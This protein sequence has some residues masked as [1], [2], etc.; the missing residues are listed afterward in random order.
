M[1]EKTKTA[2]GKGGAEISWCRVWLILLAAIFVITCVATLTIP[3]ARPRG[4]ADWGR[5]LVFIPGLSALAAT[6]LWL[7]LWLCFHWR[8]AVF[9]LACAATVIALFYAEEDWRG[10]HA[11]NKFRR[12]WEAKGERFDFAS[13][14]PP[15]VPEDQNFALTPLV[16]SSYGQMLDRTGHRLQPRNTNLVARL[17]M[18][19]WDGGNPPGNLNG[20]A[21]GEA[22]DLTAFQ[23]YY[24]E[25]AAKTNLFPVPPTPQSP[26]ADVL[27]ALSRLDPTLEELRQDAELPYSRF[28]LDYDTENKAAIVLPHLAALKRC[29]QVLALRAT[30]ELQTGQS[31]RAL[32]DITLIQRLTE[33]IHSEPFLISHLVRIAMVQLALQPVWEGLAD[34]RWTGAQLTALDADLAKLDFL[35]GYKRGM[36]CEL[37]FQGAHLDYLQMHPGKYLEL[38]NEGGGEGSKMSAAEG[39]L[40]ILM[41]LHLAP[42]GWLY[43]NRLN[44]ALAMEKYYLPVA[45][46]QSRTFNPALARRGDDYMGNESRHSTPYNVLAR[47]FLPALGTAGRRF[48]LAQGDVDLA[49]VAMALERYRLAQGRYPG[50]LD[51]LAPQYI[52]EVPHDV[53]GGQPLHYRL[54]DDGRFVLYSVGWNETDDGGVVGLTKGKPPTQ[55]IA[56]GDWVWRYP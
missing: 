53:I 43:Q 44:C 46:V 8:R 56:K 45:D 10:H 49:R 20:W 6:A 16:F 52:G 24:Q 25:Q 26:A 35:T 38:F 1:N 39:A 27:L 15:P 11:W 13:A 29:A 3:G 4:G 21:L 2:G 7:V 12:E 40:A 19:Y 18:S 55:D 5:A 17:G 9:L 42:S 54:T 14:V 23:H 50:S 36:H 34:H 37:V 48:A 41:Q 47:Q 22:T 31:D 28:P 32:A 33:A 51:P 30:A